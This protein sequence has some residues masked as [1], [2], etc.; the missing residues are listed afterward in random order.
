MKQVRIKTDNASK[1]YPALIRGNRGYVF[2]VGARLKKD[3][4]EQALREAVSSLAP[5]FPVMY[6]HLCKG[7]FDYYHVPAADF[8]V[9]LRQ[10]NPPQYLPAVFDT[11]KPSFR[12]FYSGEKLYMDVFHANADG[13]AAITYLKSLVTRYFEIKG[14]TP[15][16]IDGILYFTDEP[17]PEEQRDFY[18]DIYNRKKRVSRKE[19]TAFSLRTDRVDGLL[20]ELC[21]T[22]SLS[23]LKNYTKQKGLTVTQYLLALIYT[24]ALGYYDTDKD[25]LPIKLSVPIDLRT[26]FPSKTLR[27]YALYTNLELYPSEGYSFEQA[28]YEIKRQLKMGLHKDRLEALASSNVRLEKNVIVR[29]TPRKIKDKAIK[30]G[31]K[32]Y[33]ASK[34]TTTLSNLGMH[35]LPPEIEGE[36]ERFEM[37][38]GSG[39]GGVNFS[40]V[41]FSDTLSICISLSGED[42]KIRDTIAGK[43]LEHGIKSQCEE[44][45]IIQDS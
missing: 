15:S 35:K 7:F 36:V 23:E 6:S 32:I 41:G 37:Y 42:N 33:G 29:F 20:R 39:G 22:V 9:V 21:V 1:L 5:R 38:L 26:V 18:K 34:I 45:R 30:K 4:D 10:L 3:I 31:Y 11:Q 19:S 17:S 40:S 24:A 44:M 13:M 8:D 14:Y 2:R 25:T 27:N 12:I 28:A 16:R 43:L